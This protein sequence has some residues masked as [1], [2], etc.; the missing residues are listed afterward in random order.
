M[1]LCIIINLRDTKV[2]EQM[3]DAYV[4]VV[5][6]KKDMLDA[7]LE[8]IKDLSKASGI[9]RNTLGYVLSGKVRPSSH[10]MYALV[11]CLNLSVERA[12]IIF[13][14]PNLPNE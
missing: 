12:G 7:G 6:L 11:K 10:V 13:F 9:N 4:N 8:K 2:G 14:S 3:S 1:N 5:E